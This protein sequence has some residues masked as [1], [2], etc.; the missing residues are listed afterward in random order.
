MQT[1]A[2][3]TNPTIS[4]QLVVSSPDRNSAN[5]DDYWGVQEHLIAPI[6]G[7]FKEVLALLGHLPKQK[8]YRPLRPFS[9]TLRD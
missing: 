6:S 4:S 5:Y 8:S 9:V 2:G 1:S 7:A 3:P